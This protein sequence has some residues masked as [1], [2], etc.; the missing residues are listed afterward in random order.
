M[1]WIMGPG[2]CRGASEWISFRVSQGMSLD[3]WRYCMRN[4]L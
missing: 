3:I 1:M 4:R 2:I